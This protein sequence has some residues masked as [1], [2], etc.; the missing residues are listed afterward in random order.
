M[1]ARDIYIM[2]AVPGKTTRTDNLLQCQ[3]DLAVL[4]INWSSCR[5]VSWGLHY[6]VNV[7]LNLK[8][9]NNWQML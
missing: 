3:S 9:E 4:G 6:S 5:S 2:P 7:N 1:I 8:A